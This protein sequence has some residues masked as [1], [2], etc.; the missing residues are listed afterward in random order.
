[1][2]VQAL[3]RRVI[4]ARPPS[5]GQSKDK[6]KLG[7]EIGEQLTNTLFA[8]YSVLNCVSSFGTPMYMFYRGSRTLEEVNNPSVRTS[9]AHFGT[10]D[11]KSMHVPLNS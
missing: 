9:L 4:R 8:F 2:E 5:F 3:I 7:N 10:I 6:E 1:M 11:P